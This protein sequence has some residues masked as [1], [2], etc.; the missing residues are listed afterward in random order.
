MVEYSS[1]GFCICVEDKGPGIIH[2]ESFFDLNG[3]RKNPESRRN[4]KPRL[5]VSGR[6]TSCHGKEV[7]SNISSSDTEKV[8]E[9]VEGK[10]VS[11][12]INRTNI[13]KIHTTLHT[14]IKIKKGF[15]K[16]TRTR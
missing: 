15:D 10:N 3:R 4:L 11:L 2:K 16:V 9:H 7:S 12:E 1:G 8:Y 13:N 6:V 14:E 5:N